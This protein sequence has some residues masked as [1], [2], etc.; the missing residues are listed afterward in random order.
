[1][2]G[3]V[4]GLLVEIGG[5]TSGLQKALS[6]VN[7]VSSSLSKE[8]KGI[9]SLLK[10]DP[11]NTELLAQKQKVLAESIENTESKIKKLKEAQEEADNTIKN[12][13]SISQENYRK[14]QREIVVTEN[15]LKQLKLEASNWTQVGKKLE[16]VGNN[17]T[18]I[19]KKV[20]DLG[21]KLTKTLT[22]SILGLGAIGIKTAVDFESAFAGVE[23]TVNGTE[24]QMDELRKGIKKMS[25]ELPST[26]TEISAVAEAAGQLGIQTDNVL[27]FTK[28]MIDL[29]NSTNLSSN[30][31]ATS[32]AKFA[33]ITQMSQKDFD[34][35]GSSI[36][37]LGNNFA[38]TESEIVEMSLRLAG[39]GKQV[40][41]SEGQILGLATA[42]SSVG[43]EAEM[44]GSAISKA[45]VKMQNAVELGGKK[46]NPVLE[47]TG[48]SLRDL[49]LLSANNSKDFKN[50]ADNIG[51]TSTELNQLIK[52]G[53]ELEDFASISGMTAEQ[54]K[55]DWEE[56]ATGALTA[57][58][59]G[60]GTAEERGE[61]AIVLLSEMGLSEVRLR[62][63]L[64]RAANAGTLFND[65]IKT[66]T[67]A[68]KQNTALTNEA[69][70]RYETTASKITTTV[71]KVKNL[72]MNLGEKLLPTI[73]KI[74]DESEKWINKLS[75]LD[76]EQTENIIKIGLMVASA[77]PLIKVLG[78][79]TTTV[80]TVT[81]GIGTFSQ[82]I[83]VMSTGGVS[84]S[85]SVNTLATVLTNLASPIGIVTLGMTALAGAYAVGKVQA[86]ERQKYITDE[87][88]KIN[89]EIEGRKKLTEAVIEERNAT[90]SQ[91]NQ[92]EK[93]TKELDN[94]I[95]ENGKVKDGYKDRVD[96]I[97]NQLNTALGTEYKLTGDVISNYK[98]LKKSVEDLIKT[99]KI[100]AVLESE[101]ALYNDGIKNKAKAYESVATAQKHVNELQK[102]IAEWEEKNGKIDD[103]DFGKLIRG[104]TVTTEAHTE[105][106]VLRADLRVA[107]DELSKAE[108]NYKEKIDNIDTYTKDA[109]I[110]LGDDV[111]KQKELLQKKT[112][113]H[114]SASEDIAEATK[115]SIENY[116]YDLKMFRQYKDEAIKK[117]D[118]ASAEYYQ[119]QIETNEKSL[120]EQIQHL[121]A[122]TSTTEDMTPAQIEA[123]KKLAEGSYDIYVEELSNMHPD[124]KKEIEKITGVIVN[125]TSVEDAAKNLGRDAVLKFEE[126]S[127][128]A[129]NAGE[130]VISK[131]KEGIEN[132]GLQRGLLSAANVLG[133]NAVSE[134]R[135]G[136]SGA[137]R[138]GEN[139]VAGIKS[140]IENY[141]LQR[142]VLAAVSILGSRMTSTLNSSL[143][144]HS[145]SK[146]TEKSG[147]NFVLGAKEGILNKAK[148]LY[149][150]VGI[151]GNNLINK[152]DENVISKYFQ[153]RKMQSLEGTIN[154]NMINNTNTI[155]T[156]PQI[157]FNVQQLD[158]S[159]LEQCF[160]YVNRKFG[161][162]Y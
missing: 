61:S 113:A 125:D 116:Q 118:T 16:E 119:I 111:E 157:V 1:M 89:E 100:N 31:A 29:G 74:L 107:Q 133:S 87:I 67:K 154:S 138:A 131:A 112:I 139:F 126:S 28:T 134:F 68:W 81:K 76:D 127:S 98:D 150:T 21:D 114:Q 63:S 15:K 145:P 35:L 96:F 36:V 41:M 66:G 3:S 130:N 106:N 26:T 94:L 20:T 158:E 99:K 121:A 37:D 49:E 44:G 73:N 5:D 12:G 45:L 95:D 141:G 92:I 80:G 93:L 115:L 39:A 51:M 110:L 10:L 17:I 22:T 105:L 103:S 149:N 7:S 38:T 137:Q 90:F 14:L 57:F 64:L 43:I 122:M 69:N 140:G 88:D 156:T 102:K 85:T 75:K 162:K 79:L 33:N 161:S 159:K 97:L 109:T 153:I 86:K 56:D 34:K 101:E 123:W 4:K 47:K 46:L 11:K 84:A 58:I 151:F 8:L 54:F 135:S 132:Y 50:L 13:G 6:K 55:K 42:L 9:N 91:M 128:E 117:Q 52:S 18:K 129:K 104:L 83:G 70:K 143:D 155:V 146:I 78:M 24:E 108:T 147:E 27:S 23:K 2:A 71:N 82:A 72:V 148:D 32:L 30:E 142:G 53:S 48:M 59:K 60:L 62:D 124:T 136:S 77:G 152:F 120:K 144:E 160:N 40:G 19:G 65:A 25:T